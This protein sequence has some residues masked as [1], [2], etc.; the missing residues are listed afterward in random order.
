MFSGFIAMASSIKAKLS[1][2]LAPHFGERLDAIAQ[3]Q[4]CVPANAIGSAV[5][6]R[7]GLARLTSADLLR[8]TTQIDFFDRAV[9]SHD[10]QHEQ[11]LCETFGTLHTQRHR[12]CGR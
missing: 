10:L 7:S 8:D 9:V 6:P 11:L 12:A 1:R 5:P 2:V 3:V 4:L